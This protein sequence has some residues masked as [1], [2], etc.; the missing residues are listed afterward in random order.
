VQ[1][2]LFIL[3]AL[4]SGL[5]HADW[6]GVAINVSDSETDWE[7]GNDLRVAR[8]TEFSFRIEEKT[9]PGLRVGASIGQVSL[10]VKR[11][12]SAS[13]Q[14]FDTQFLSI[15]LRQPFQLNETWGLFGGMNYKYHLGSDKDEMNEAEI[16]WSEIDFYIGASLELAHIRISPM[17]YHQSVDGDIDDDSGSH[18]FELDDPI[19]AAIRI[20]YFVEKT[21]FVRLEFQT[22][23]REGIVLT[24]AREY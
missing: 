12:A 20:D 19:S 13:D 1:F 14:N 4:F 16:S 18:D 10:R 24:F 5:A 6:S 17:M 8:S 11:D 15:N 3:L 2:N 9:E 21:A 23:N 7:I 22:G